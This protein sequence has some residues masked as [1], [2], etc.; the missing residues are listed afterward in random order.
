MRMCCR[1]MLLDEARRRDLLIEHPH[2]GIL[3]VDVAG[4]AI[5]AL[6]LCEATLGRA[7]L[8]ASCWRSLRDA[9]SFSGQH[10]T[11]AGIR[12]AAFAE[13][14]GRRGAAKSR[15]PFTAASRATRRPRST[16]DSF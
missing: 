13:L 14:C 7:I 4:R 5:V 10:G 11:L 2:A 12:T 6:I 3:R 1:V 15:R 8:A 16:S 9:A